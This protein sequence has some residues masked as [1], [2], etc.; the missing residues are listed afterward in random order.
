MSVFVSQQGDVLS[1]TKTA[2]TKCEMLSLARERVES[3]ADD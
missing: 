3:I 2:I 1:S